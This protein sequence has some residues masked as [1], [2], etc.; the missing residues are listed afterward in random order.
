M[1]HEG[2]DNEDS[3]GDDNEDHEGTNECKRVWT[4]A[5]WRPHKL[6]QVAAEQNEHKWRTNEGKIRACTY[7]VRATPAAPAEQGGTNKCD[8]AWTRRYK[9]AWLSV[10]EGQMRAKQ[11]W[12]SSG[13]LARM[14]MDGRGEHGH[15]GAKAGGWNKCKRAGMNTNKRAGGQVRAGQGP[16]PSPNCFSFF[17]Y[18]TTWNRGLAAPFHPYIYLN[19]YICIFE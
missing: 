19:M 4:K 11:A 10:N 15:G 1:A 2:G 17:L 18:L 16:T 13:A 5:K 7:G 8:W 14:S 6:D 3:K 12:S 9:R